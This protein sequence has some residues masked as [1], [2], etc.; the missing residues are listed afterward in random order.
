M[1]AIAGRLAIQEGA[2]Y[3][4]RPYGGRGV[5]LGGVPGVQRGKVLILG[6]GVVGTHAAKMAVGL[7]ADVT[8]LD[9]SARRLAELDDLFAGPRA[10]AV[11]ERRQPRAQ[12]GA[13]RSGD[14]R[15]ARAGRVRAEA[16]PPRAPVGD[17]AR[18]L[19]IVDVAVDQ[20]G[21]VETDARDHRTTSRSTPSTACCTTRCRT[22]RRRSRARRRWR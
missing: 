12:L 22:C 17:A 7:G 16:D 21:C 5:L 1:S 4:E 18:A 19:L 3:L 11:L 15:G 20:G 14:R 10:D 8:I 13:G 6:G 9:L 2:K